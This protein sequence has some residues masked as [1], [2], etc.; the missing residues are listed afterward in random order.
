MRR[1]WLKI[2]ETNPLPGVCGRVCY[3][4][5]EFACN[6]AEIDSIVAT[7]ALERY[8]ADS[9]RQEPLPASSPY[10][11]RPERVAVIGSGP[12][13]LSC[14]YHLAR[15]GYPV[16]IFE[17][18]GRPGGMLRSGIPPYRLPREILDKE[19]DD[20]LGLGVRL[21]LEA[22]LGVDLEWADLQ[23]FDAIFLAT[24]AHR[25]RRLG[26]RGEDAKGVLS[27]LEFLKAVNAG[28]PPAIGRRVLVVGGGNTA[29][30]AARTSLRRGSEVAVVYRRSRQEMPAVLEEVQSALDE[31]VQMQF[32]TAPVQI[33]AEYGKVRGMEVQRMELGAPDSSGRRVPT[34][35]PGS[36]YYLQA[37]AILTA[38]GEEPDTHYMPDDAEI[39]GQRIL[40]DEQQDTRR[41]GIYAG[42]D[43]ATSAAATV[44]Y[45]IRSGRIAAEAIHRKLT[46]EP[47]Q[48]LAQRVIGPML[49]RAA[50]F[51]RAP[52]VELPRREIQNLPGDFDE[53]NLGLLEASAMYEAGRCLRCGV[54]TFCNNCL[55]FRPD[56][57]VHLSPSGRGYEI[58]QSSMALLLS[59]RLRCP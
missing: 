51:R 14:A 38:I 2:L 19:I 53:I 10:M 18:E 58:G 36:N 35:I 26:V 9:N 31:G 30:D 5:C 42:G 7:H 15:R 29:V 40:V 13:E 43:A 48:P 8:V 33:V 4:P 46:N 12:A 54:C 22:T 25:S 57:A 55:I 23:G 47:F 50:H 41:P 17:S 34:P 39:K 6:R 24:G 45:A 56:T 20:I 52:R 32:L 16:V 28:F 21:E 27:G 44:A 1:A 37:D 49:I 3:H 11:P 59:Q